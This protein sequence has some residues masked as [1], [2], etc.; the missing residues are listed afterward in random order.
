[1]ELTG[2]VR[3]TDTIDVVQGWNMIGSISGSASVGNIVQIP[4]GIVASSY[5]GYNGAYIV[6]TTIDPARGY[7]VKVNQNGKLVLTVGGIVLHPEASPS[8]K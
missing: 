6:A 3:T 2:G 8:S 1:M 5:Y 4:G 7:W